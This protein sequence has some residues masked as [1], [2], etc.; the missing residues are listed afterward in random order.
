[1]V[2]K[3]RLHAQCTENLRNINTVHHCTQHT[4]LIR[5][6]TLNDL[7]A[8]AS[9]PEIAAADD[10]RNLCSLICNLLHLFGNLQA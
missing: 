1:M 9:A 8:V 5:L 4:D 2:Y 10:N 6:R 7:A 3:L